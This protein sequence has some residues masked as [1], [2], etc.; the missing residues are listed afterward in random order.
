MQQELMKLRD[1]GIIKPIKNSTLVSNLML[2]R[3]NNGD[4]RLCV[5]L[6]YL[7]VSSLNESY[8]FPNMEEMMQKVTNIEF[9]S[10]MDGVF[11]IQP[12][13][14]ERIRKI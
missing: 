5:D 12:S 1:R 2:V 14:G 7:N 13:E 10:M 8:P 9:L 3:K 4:I 6:K 11:R